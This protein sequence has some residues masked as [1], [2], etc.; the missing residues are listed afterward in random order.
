MPPLEVRPYV[1]PRP[2]DE[3]ERDLFYGRDREAADLCSLVIAHA[4]V[5]FYAPSGA[6]KTSLLQARLIPL[7]KEKEFEVLR[8]AR[9]R[10]PAFGAGNAYVRG[11]LA[12]WT[13]E[14]APPSPPE[15][16]LGEF[17]AARPCRRDDLGEPLP[18]VLV[19]DQAEEIFDTG[20]WQDRRELFQQLGAALD[21]DP[22]LRVVL[23]LR[24]EYLARLDP[25]A[26][27]MPERL[28]IHF[29]LEPLRRSAA[30][31]AVIGPLRATA[32]HFAPG[33]AEK[34]VDDLMQVATADGE[35]EEKQELVEPVQLQAVCQ[36][37]WNALPADV[38]EVTAEHLRTIGDVDKALAAFYEDCLREAVQGAA[39]PEGRL[40]LWIEERLITPSGKRGLVFQGE[41]ETEGLPNKTVALLESGHLVRGEWRAR[42]CWFELTHDRLIE[43]IRC[44]NQRWREGRGIAVEALRRLENR[45]RQ[46][47]LGKEEF[48][49]EIE[50]RE[51]QRLVGDDPADSAAS[52][53]LRNLIEVSRAR[54]ERLRLRK[55]TAVTGS[56]AV[57]A[58][59]ALVLALGLVR[60]VKVQ[61]QLQVA[62]QLAL[63]AGSAG[64]RNT[65]RGLLLAVEAN[66]IARNAGQ[67]RIPTAEEALRGSLAA[68]RGFP[69]GGEGES[70]ANFAVSPDG[71]WLAFA[72]RDG[73]L[74]LRSF[75]AEGLVGLPVV[76]PGR[77]K[78][79]SAVTATAGHAWVVAID[80]E[81]R[82]FLWEGKSG[83]RRLTIDGEPLSRPVLGPNGQ[84]LLDADRQKPRYWP[85]AAGAIAGPAVDLTCPAG[86]V[87][88]T[89][90]SADFGAV[91][92]GCDDGTILSWGLAGRG[93]ARPLRLHVAREPSALAVSPDRRRVAA[94]VPSQAVTVWDSA[95]KGDPVQVF[96]GPPADQDV[97]ALAFSPDGRWLA[98]G[99][100]GS[101]RLWSLTEPG[102]A[103]ALKGDPG[104]VRSLAFTGG[105]R[106]VV[107]GGWD[108]PPRAWD[109][110]TFS[111][112][113]LG[114]PE[115]GANVAATSPAEDQVATVDR[116]GRLMLW[117][118]SSLDTH[119]TVLRDQEA[120]LGTGLFSLDGRWLLTKPS[121]GGASRIWDVAAPRAGPEP[122]RFGRDAEHFTLSPDGRWLVTLPRD[123]RA[124]LWSLKE[125][126]RAPVTLALSEGDRGLL[127]SFS[128]DSRRLAIA[129]PRQLQLL[130]LVDLH[131]SS[132]RLAL[133]EPGG[134]TAVT[135]PTSRWLLV[136]AQGN[137]PRL[138][139]LEANEP[140][141]PQ[142]L[143]LSGA[144]LQQPVAL[145][146]GG[147]WMLATA[148]DGRPRLWDLRSGGLPREL[149]LRRSQAELVGAFSRD[150]RWLA[151]GDGE[152]FVRLWD[153]PEL[154]RRAG[155]GL[156][157]EPFRSYRHDQAVT[158]VVFSGDGAW[159]AAGSRDQTASLL[160][161]SASDGSPR[162]LFGHG[163]AVTS[164]AADPNG[165]LATGS[166][167]RTVRLWN[168]GSDN[169]G[170][171]S[172]TLPA[173]ESAGAVRSVAFSPDG[174]WLVT[175]DDQGVVRRWNLHID[176]LVTLA[177][178]LAGRN[179]G[180][181]ERRQYLGNES[182]A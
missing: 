8:P 80:G 57:L 101:V 92:I 84:W 64:S 27:Q 149:P 93:A 141:T 121:K 1:G 98:S 165:W 106:T 180:L 11:I 163:G 150:G 181:D 118:F 119:T 75:D 161:L 76:L 148:D 168:L 152:G 5:L 108:G 151:T 128:G 136:A 53:D 104:A 157:L 87:A 143:D 173:Q 56:I 45:S 178:R 170:A 135:D 50:V 63:A 125:Q 115:D 40:R 105:G 140:D 33:I 29:R 114:R 61:R 34:L 39:V 132:R 20:P 54:I 14:G 134:E 2:F 131:F 129:Y 120:R 47:R 85:L 133:S 77:L 41:E 38:V 15:T 23:A 130:D 68:V 24:E 46:W 17:L 52:S 81:G 167:D 22:R 21:A 49:D 32:C 43:P 182:A 171:T 154:R 156:T 144:T 145:S 9:V 73:P 18:R 177:C 113:A 82:S 26:A 65:E 3:K 25:F 44:S 28:R 88:R 112:T 79:V 138:W 71:R 162:W 94:A 51:A 31:A 160:R 166:E 146:P 155:R 179:L 78:E 169:P 74:H 58:V 159:L 6:G 126:S 4:A 110:T 139:D 16:T 30:L 117:D 111:A 60:N 109:L 89:A 122:A 83:P 164:L 19:F 69:V 86:P 37:L 100:S 66:R 102:V 72:A 137:P 35:S 55:L 95:S 107:A 67:E 48:L 90:F 70:P 147:N 12:A 176:E 142:G 123:G 103:K 153:L 10:A 127:A 175:A 116:E 62:K 174:H 91:A 99:G 42:A 59:I 172:I 97:T 158:V 13:P 96:T 7:L 124:L 36:R